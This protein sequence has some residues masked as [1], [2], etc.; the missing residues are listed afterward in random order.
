M[1]LLVTVHVYIRMGGTRATA[2]MHSRVNITYAVFSGN[3]GAMLSCMLVNVQN[4]QTSSTCQA[5]LV[6]C[7]SMA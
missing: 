4:V 6:G 3:R 5:Q 2:V 1:P 7:W